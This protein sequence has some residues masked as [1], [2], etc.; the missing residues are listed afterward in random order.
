M[1]RRPRTDR[2]RADGSAAADQPVKRLTAPAVLVRLLA[3][4]MIQ[5][6][7]LATLVAIRSSE[8]RSRERS[9]GNQ[10]GG[11]RCATGLAASALAVALAISATGAS[12][13]TISISCGAVGLELQLCQEAPTPGPRRPAMRSTS[14]RR[15]I[16]DRAPGP[17]PADPGGQLGRHRRL[18]D[19]RDLAGHPGQP[20]HR[21]RR[22]HRSGAIDQHF[23]AIVA[24][25]TVDDALVA[26]PWFTD[27]G[28]LYY[29]TDLLE[30]YG[31]QPPTTWQEL[32]ETPKEIQ[33][34][35]R[36]AG[37]DKMQGF[38]FQGKAYE[39]LTCNALEWVDSFGG[40][41][42][43]PTTADHDQQPQGGGS[44]RSGGILDRQDRAR[45]RAELRRG[46]IA[47]RVPVRQRRV[48]A[49]LAL[50]LG[51]RQ[52]AR[53][54]DQGQDR[55]RP[56]AQ[57]RRRTASTPARSAAGSSR[58]PS[59]RRTPSSRSIWSST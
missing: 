14:S 37:N 26:M 31:K 27:A 55:G 15:P 5:N 34:G 10:S 1:A 42:S 6:W 43:W 35:E 21:S 53:Q 20:L 30:K 8:A 44:A 28:L 50:R 59:I 16:G 2:C 57:G 12:A 36:G 45:G 46:G 38:V 24:N 51:A 23:Q 41:R 3:A 18:S 58:S 29:R 52:R 7:R 49:Q 9:Q 17:L 56:A 32:T 40:G 48:H 19:R 33:D 25:N 11:V 39:G 47:R 22:A 13:A 54:P 4:R